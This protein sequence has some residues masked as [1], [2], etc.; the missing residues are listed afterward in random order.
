MDGD[1][2]NM[3][4]FAYETRLDVRFRDHDT[5]GHVNNAV[6]ATY[7]EEAR[8]RYYRDVLDVSVEDVS[9]VLAHFEIDYVRAIETASS[10]T[11]AASVTAVGTSSFEMEYEIRVDGEVAATAEATQVVYDEEAGE[12]RPVPDEWRERFAEVEG[13]EF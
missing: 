3:T 5:L 12:P 8:V 9:T 4:E 7:C 10:V 1:A 6:Y 2:G 11:V 13:R